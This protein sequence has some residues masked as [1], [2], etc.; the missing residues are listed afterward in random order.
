MLSQVYVSNVVY[1][2]SVVLIRIKRFILKQKWSDNDERVTIR[3]GC[4]QYDK[5]GQDQARSE[6][7]MLIRLR[8]IDPE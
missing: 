2:V 4:V 3:T 1:F 5:I 6:P 7:H 8:Y